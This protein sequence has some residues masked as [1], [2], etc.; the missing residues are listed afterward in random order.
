MKMTL[1]QHREFG[2][3]VQQFREL[4]L[5]PHVLFTGTKRSKEYRAV[6][7]ALKYI[8]LMRSELDN[9]VCRDFPDCSDATKIY[10]WGGWE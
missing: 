4:L 6:R 10:Y 3:Q 1:E 2:E 7:K 8:D 5:Q 9:V